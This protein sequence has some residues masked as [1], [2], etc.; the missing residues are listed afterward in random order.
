MDGG[1][2]DANGPNLG[3]RPLSEQR[4]GRGDRVI[5]DLEIPRLDIDGNNFARVACFNLRADPPFVELFAQARV[6]FL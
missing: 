3:I 4:R 6:L 1:P 5:P 2:T